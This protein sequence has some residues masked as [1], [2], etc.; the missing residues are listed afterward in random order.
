MKRDFF[1][2]PSV[3]KLARILFFAFTGPREAELSPSS[4]QLP[5]ARSDGP[6]DGGRRRPAGPE[7]A[8]PEVAG[9][10]VAGPEDIAQVYN[11]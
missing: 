6:R 11:I 1:P 5:R 9:P 2:L 10:E 7:V 8:G 3:F 4:S